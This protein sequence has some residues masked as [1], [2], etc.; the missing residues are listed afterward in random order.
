MNKERKTPRGAEPKDP[1]G[2]VRLFTHKNR[3]SHCASARNHCPVSRVTVQ[4]KMLQK[5]QK[6]KGTR[7]GRAKEMCENGDGLLIR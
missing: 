1:L 3:A 7:G 4:H 2:N 6:Q 5:K